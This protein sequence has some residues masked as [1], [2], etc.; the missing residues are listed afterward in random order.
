VPLLH[1]GR[2]V[3]VLDLDSPEPGRFDAADAAGLEQVAALFSTATDWR[4]LL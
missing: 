4:S 1:A 3:G 2:V